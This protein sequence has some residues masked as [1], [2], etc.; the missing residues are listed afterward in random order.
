MFYA[1]FW[2]SYAG[3]SAIINILF[4]FPQTDDY[5]SCLYIFLNILLFAIFSPLIVY[6]TLLLDSR[7]WQG[8][9]DSNQQRNS[10]YLFG[11]TRGGSGDTG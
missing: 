10:S 6:W 11:H 4:L 1:K 3:I 7:W 9:D 2:G 8:I 5:G